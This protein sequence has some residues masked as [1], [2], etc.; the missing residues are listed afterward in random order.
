MDDHDHFTDLSHTLP[1]LAA[2]DLPGEV[3]HRPMHLFHNHESSCT[4][5]V[6]DG[7]E[8]SAWNLP[9]QLNTPAAP[10]IA[11]LTLGVPH[12]SHDDHCMD[13]C[14]GSYDSEGLPRGAYPPPTAN[15][16]SVCP[17]TYPTTEMQSV[18]PT[19]DYQQPPAYYPLM[20]GA[21]NYNYGSTGIRSV[22]EAHN[23][24][25]HQF[26]NSPMNGP[27]V[28][29]TV[30]CSNLN[31]CVSQG[32]GSGSCSELCCTDPGCQ[33]TVCHGEDCAN[34][35]DQCHDNQCF[36]STAPTEDLYSFN[37]FNHDEWNL[38]GDPGHGLLHHDPNCNHT[39][40]EHA[41]AITL[42]H[43]KNP[44]AVPQYSRG[45][46]V[47]SAFNDGDVD[48]TAADTPALTADTVN[49]SPMSHRPS[50]SLP[51][52]AH[53]APGKDLTCQWLVGD[54]HNKH[55]CGQVFSSTEEL[56]AHLGTDHVGNMNSKTRYLCCWAG[57]SRKDDQVFASRN[58]L[59][60]HISTHTAFKPFKCEVCQESFSA[61]Q[62]LD[63]HVRIHTG[64]RPY[65][66]DF[67]GCEKSFKQKS[68]LTMH[69][70]THTGEKPLRCDVCGKKFGE[71]S[72]LSKHRK[73]HDRQ[74]IFKCS[75]CPRAFVRLDQLRRHEKRHERDQKKSV[76]A[77]QP[78]DFSTLEYDRKAEALQVAESEFADMLQSL[79]S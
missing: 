32:C 67:E 33:N 19:Q 21:R 30:Q 73:L 24:N 54:V 36:T 50:L 8:P 60:R 25:G 31:D 64:E 10:T 12:T 45:Y 16:P 41:A 15:R 14:P 23:N 1:L 69:K 68:A 22:P 72:N 9:L 62:A 4:D 79:E 56:H 75:T 3:F 35:G 20:M 57:C 71:S 26:S 27:V 28:D 77:H 34:Q 51:D 43:L 5:F 58:K 46:S 78:I 38:D 42:E 40:T 49:A 74:Y 61:Q 53:Q 29:T 18:Q 6:F 11:P 66:C 44:V 47:A 55:V 7:H 76:E 2:S 70:R 37:H 59:R 17:G 65:Q 63:Q 39:H 13:A 48:M 52:A